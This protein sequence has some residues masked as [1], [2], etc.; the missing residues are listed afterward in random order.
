MTQDD[1]KLVGPVGDATVAISLDVAMAD[2]S[3][4]LADWDG[5][6]DRLSELATIQSARLSMPI[7]IRE[8]DLSTT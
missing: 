6:R 2:I 4:F 3:A 5:L 1:T 8:I 7:G